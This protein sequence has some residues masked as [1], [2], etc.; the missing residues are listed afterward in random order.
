MG[1]I[2]VLTAARKVKSILDR[3]NIRNWVGKNAVINVQ[4]LTSC[5][6]LKKWLLGRTFI[7]K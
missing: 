2:P 3:I 4:Y 1:S 5:R 7:P 6:A